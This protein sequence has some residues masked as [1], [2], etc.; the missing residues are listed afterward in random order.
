MFSISRRHAEENAPEGRGCV[1]M[2]KFS[3]FVVGFLM[4]IILPY[5]IAYLFNRDDRE[6]RYAQCWIASAI[7][8]AF[9]CSRHVE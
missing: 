7:A 6:K 5:G 1:T 2:R 8:F 3:A 4:A 9:E